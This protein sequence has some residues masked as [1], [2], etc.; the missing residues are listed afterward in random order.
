MISLINWLLSKLFPYNLPKKLPMML[1][2]Q[3]V[4]TDRPKGG[5]SE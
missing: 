4:V 2:L 1:V 5:L 3:G